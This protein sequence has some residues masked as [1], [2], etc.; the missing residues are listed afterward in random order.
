MT[1]PHSG[2]AAGFAWTSAVFC[3][4]AGAP[5]TYQY[6]RFW[7][8]GLAEYILKRRNGE[9]IAICL[10]IGARWVMEGFRQ[11]GIVIRPI[12]KKNENL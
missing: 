5:L 4:V 12:S 7:V 10:A 2:S 9:G 3:F 6:R 1:P 8:L 11:N